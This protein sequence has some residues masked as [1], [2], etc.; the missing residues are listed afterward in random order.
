MARRPCQR[1]N[2][3]H[4]S[5]IQALSVLR[6]GSTSSSVG[7]AWLAG[8][9]AG[10]LIHCSW[11]GMIASDGERTLLFSQRPGQLWPSL[12]STEPDGP[13]SGMDGRERMGVGLVG[14]KIISPKRSDVHIWKLAHVFCLSSNQFLHARMIIYCLRAAATLTLIGIGL[15]DRVEKARAADLASAHPCDNGASCLVCVGGITY[16]YADLEEL[17]AILSPQDSSQSSPIIQRVKALIRQG[18]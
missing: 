11:P 15:V 5:T 4:R 14:S 9:G 17:S 10:D 8:L 6:T 12:L 1:R 13:L 7:L 16:L 18:P 3:R 2:I